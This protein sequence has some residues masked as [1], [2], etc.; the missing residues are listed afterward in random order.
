MNYLVKQIVNDDG[1][2]VDPGDQ[3]W[4][5]M[6]YFTG[7]TGMLCTGEFVDDAATSGNGSLYEFKNVGRGG[8]TCHNCLAIVKQF[9]AVRL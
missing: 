4:H 2:P 6:Q 7:D 1:D 5:L 9:K 3:C 8:I